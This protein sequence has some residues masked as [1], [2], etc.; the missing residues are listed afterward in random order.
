[1]ALDTVILQ[2]RFTSDG[3]AKTIP[4]RSDVDWMFVYNYTAATTPQAGEGVVFYW[5]RGLAINDGF[6]DVRNAGATADLWGTALGLGVGGFTLVDS[7]LQSPGPSV[8]LTVITAANHPVVTTGSTATL[9]PG[10]IVRIINPDNQPQI[11]G[12]DFTIGQGTFTGVTF[13]LDYIDLTG[14]VASTAGFWRKIFY[15]PIF[16]PRRRFIT[17]ITQA[18]KA[19]VTLSVKHGYTVGQ[20]VRFQVPAIFGMTQMDGLIGEIT[21]V[22]TNATTNTITVNIDSSAFSP[23]VFPA[24]TDVPFTPAQ[25]VPIGEGTDVS[26]ADPNLLDDATINTAFIGITLA[27]GI[28]SPAGQ[29]EDIIYWRAGKS[30]SVDNT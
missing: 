27:A 7:S 20:E 30:F 16:Y 9:S 6:A 25:V 19:V 5:Q 4:L 22:T 26:I 29:A 14:S 18:A 17:N 8:A 13:S 15:D 28:S 24:A 21:A 1:M 12:M 2:G 10:D 23:F 11:G 3:T